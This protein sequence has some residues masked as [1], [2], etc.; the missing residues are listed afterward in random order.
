MNPLELD[1][2][3]GIIARGYE[4][5]AAAS[6]ELLAIDDPASA[7][8]WLGEIAEQI[9]DAREQPSGPTLHIA[10]TSRGLARL[11]L[12]GD[13]I[14]QLSAEFREGMVTRERR[15]ALGDE[16]ANAPE[17]WR[18]GGPSTEAIDILLMLFATDDHA[19]RTLRQS[20]I[21]RWERSGLR[22]VCHLP[23]VRLPGRKEHFG[24]RDGIGQPL[25]E[26]LDAPGTWRNT[27]RPGE[28][29][30]GYINEHDE[31]PTT[32]TVNPTLDR[33]GV[34]L[35][36][37]LNATL[38][39]FGRNGSY[40][41]FRQLQQDVSTFWRVMDEAA[42]RP[43]GSSDP[44]AR[45]R[46]AAQ[47]IGRWP[48]GAPLALSPD[49]D[50]PSLA[51]ADEFSYRELDP[52]GVK[53]PIG[54]HARRMNPRDALELDRSGKESLQLVKG[55]RIMRRPRSYGPPLAASMHA[56][57]LANAANDG[58]ERGLHFISFQASIRRQ[59][60][61]L[62]Q[63]WGINEKFA[64]LYED[65][66][67]LLASREPGDPGIFT[68]PG[69]PVRRRLHRLPRFVQVRGGGYFFMPGRR[70]VRFLST[71]A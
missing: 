29:I 34:L 49:R 69:V 8:R 17:T 41:V 54:S 28:I 68:L 23:S 50:D 31:Y 61:F 9:H 53:C 21:E 51:D 43:D 64:G 52:H 27:I 55:R 24:F 60:E 11:G 19:L 26:G 20:C 6:S 65:K 15:R 38:K 36:Y 39:D 56:D 62:Q 13:V 58:V 16:G 71:L 63:T 57:D 5:L 18:W 47:M 59:F 37:R 33:D 45:T 46:L 25:L 22:L 42:R 14:A 67:P 44:E 12:P 40:L 48:S 7:R 66:D 2:I 1:D 35:P 10:F 32:P 70:A 4:D 30:F 3:Q